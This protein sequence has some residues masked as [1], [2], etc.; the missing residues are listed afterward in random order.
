MLRIID[1]S[2]WIEMD[3]RER[4]DKLVEILKGER[5]E[6]HEH[7]DADVGGVSGWVDNYGVSDLLDRLNDPRNRLMLE[8]ILSGN[9]NNHDEKP[10]DVFLETINTAKRYYCFEGEFAPD[11]KEGKNGRPEA[12]GLNIDMLYRICKDVSDS[13]YLD[14][15][16]NILNFTKLFRKRV[17]EY[18]G[19][20]LK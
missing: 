16:R 3:D 8:G 13:F 9:G 10:I 19:S 12:I 18:I 4:L 15:G 20:A 6:E 2:W 11:P 7:N 1:C 5:N 14:S 17:N